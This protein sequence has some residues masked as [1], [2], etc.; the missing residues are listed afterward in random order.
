[1]VR[2]YAARE[3][4]KDKETHADFPDIV[5]TYGLG[6][7]AARRIPCSLIALS[8]TAMVRRAAL[9]FMGPS[10]VA[11]RRTIL[12]LVE[13]PPAITGLNAQRLRSEPM[14]CQQYTTSLK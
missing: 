1:M 8:P 9:L 14:S 10:R 12:D 6:A 11:L 4:D 13:A 3:K 7:V 5:S 2:S